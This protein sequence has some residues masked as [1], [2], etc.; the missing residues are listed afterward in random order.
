MKA[1]L[2]AAGLGSRL[3]P[4]TNKVPKCLVTVNDKTMLQFWIEKVQDAGVKDILINTHY[5]AE[6]VTEFLGDFSNQKDISIK[7]SYEKQLL[8][9]AGTLEN[10]KE[11]LSDGGGFFCLHVDNYTDINLC[12]MLRHHH[13]RRN[14]C[15]I[16]IATFRT[17]SP[18]SCGIVNVDENG[19]VIPVRDF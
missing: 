12:D 17:D 10:N 8:G 19:R 2:L 14:D 9:T 6:V 15:V 7:L 1:V 4:L 5:K 13:L 11:W 16:T 3:R 18:K